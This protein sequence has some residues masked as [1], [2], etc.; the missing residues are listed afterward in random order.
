VSR[1]SEVEGLRDGRKETIR[2]LRPEDRDEFSAAVGRTSNQSIYRRF[3]TSRRNF[4]DSETSFFVNVDFVKHVALIAALQAD[5]R[6]DVGGS[7]R[8][9]VDQPGRR[10][11]PLWSWTNIRAK[12][13]ARHFYVT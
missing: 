13:S 4:S 9:V 11:W 12:E 3:F 6:G 5:H 2:S 1:Y 7:G 10:S 8:Y